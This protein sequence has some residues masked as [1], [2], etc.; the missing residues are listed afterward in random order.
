[1][2][3]ISISKGI[4]YIS[5]DPFI[6][7]N[8]ENER[9]K[10]KEES[11]ISKIPP[12]NETLL[13]GNLSS[14]PSKSS[15]ENRTPTPFAPPTPPPTHPVKN[16]K[17]SV[18]HSSSWKLVES[19]K[20]A[21]NFTGVRQVGQVI[22]F[23]GSGTRPTTSKLKPFFPVPRTARSCGNPRRRTRPAC[24]HGT[25]VLVSMVTY[26]SPP[27]Q[28][29]LARRTWHGAGDAGFHPSVRAQRRG[30]SRAA[31][32]FVPVDP[33]R[34]ILSFPEL[35]FFSP[36]NRSSVDRKNVSKKRENGRRSNRRGGDSRPDS[37]KFATAK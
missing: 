20:E 5:L 9:E 37:S 28:P 15:R 21:W 2:R 34:V 7:Q 17:P 32:T 22:I 8:R 30:G 33:G 13:Q 4:L 19:W 27:P 10:R 31:Q 23:T 24:K 26:T 36:L 35:L 18:L 11:V 25:L 6:L 12:P 1:M 3:D 16:Q 29:L 14:R